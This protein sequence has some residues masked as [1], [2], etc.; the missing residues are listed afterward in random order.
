MRAWIWLL[1]A[2]LLGAAAFWAS[3]GPLRRPS[4]PAPP[5]RTSERTLQP[6]AP[7]ARA[8]TDRRATS[9]AE[10]AA[11]DVATVSGRILDALERPLPGVEV[12]VQSHAE[13]APLPAPEPN[14]TTL[15]RTR[16]GADGTFTIRH[17]AGGMGTVVL[18][19]AEYP[20]QLAGEVA[21]RAG[22]RVD[23]GDLRLQSRPGL[24]VEVRAAGTDLPVSGARVELAPNLDDALLPGYPL[25]LQRRLA[26]TERDGR[27]MLLGVDAG[28][29]ELRISAPGFATRTLAHQQPVTELPPEVRVTLDAGA[30]LR[31]SVRAGSE[32][33]AAAQV[34]AVPLAA[35]SIASAR[36]NELGEFRLEGLTLAS[37][38]IEAQ[39]ARHG[40]LRVPR[41]DVR[42][43]PEP[44]L[45]DFGQ[46]A[47]L[48]GI[49]LDP[50]GRPL[51]G[52][53]LTAVPRAGN[54]ELP[55]RLARATSAADGSFTLPGLASEE[56][57]ILVQA[58]GLPE[59]EFGPWIPD[60]QVH[61]LR[62][63][64]G[65]RLTGQVF[66]PF[67]QPLAGATVELASE[68][69][70][71]SEFAAFLDRLRGSPATGATGADGRFEI[72]GAPA[73][74]WRIVVRAAGH[75]PTATHLLPVP[76]DRWIDAGPIRIAAGAFVRG[77]ARCADAAPARQV[78][79]C[80]DPVPDPQAPW[81]EALTGTTDSEGNFALG[82]AA[83]G[84]YELSFFDPGPGVV[85][86]AA[87]LRA[88]SRVRL[89]LQPGA[90]VRQDLQERPR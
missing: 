82:P 28:T 71:G 50:S 62:L 35:G 52:A 89:Q 8:R 30:I 79:V 44:V 47:A 38:R 32:P 87:D 10:L 16:S 83:P 54:L 86:A 13:A 49:V 58:R 73:R 36:T 70:D 85:A 25:A 77:R 2:A 84:D 55:G 9:A 74:P 15:A 4:T 60:A 17:R 41:I 18:S 72:R 26:Q 23:L 59:Q 63:D 6:A 64:P 11:G 78:R 46:G 57:R 3:T 1:L 80:L 48:R 14:T 43:N 66:G 5:E 51:A 39:S 42:A 19:H 27:A 21:L 40:V 90:D 67:G 45:L 29:Y 81:R 31:G 12:V 61:P 7:G 65:L 68:E 69:R 76:P 75:P 88:R 56:H 20:P 33:V 34:V 37:Y 53:E 24:R 22:E